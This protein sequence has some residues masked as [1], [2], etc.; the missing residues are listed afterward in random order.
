MGIL[1][2]ATR[3]ATGTTT[4]FWA[5][6]KNLE[7]GLATFSEGWKVTYEVLNKK[8]KDSISIKERI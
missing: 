5:N 2:T 3:T 8:P 4:L 6:A 7:A 1:I